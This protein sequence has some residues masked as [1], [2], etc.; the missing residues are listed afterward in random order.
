MKVLKVNGNI[1]IVEAGGI[2]K[3][4]D[5]SLMDAVEKNDYVIVHAGFAIQTMNEEEAM[6]TLS[7]FDEMIQLMKQETA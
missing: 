2:H 6:K 7:I 5:L 3:T 4:I 1:G